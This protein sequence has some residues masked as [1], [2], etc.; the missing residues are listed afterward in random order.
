M[1]YVGVFYP[2]M[3]SIPSNYKD[4]LMSCFRFL[5]L[6]QLLYKKTLQH[7]QTVAA[8]SEDRMESEE[9]LNKDAE[10]TLTLI[11]LLQHVIHQLGGKLI[12]KLRP[13]LIQGLSHLLLYC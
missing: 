5:P 6:W 10:K 2:S 4:R 3:L 13:R 8:Q 1:Y 7:Y 11:K 9:I 12:Q